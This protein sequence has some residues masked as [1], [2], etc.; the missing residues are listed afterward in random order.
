MSGDE[1]PTVAVTGALFVCFTCRQPIVTRNGQ[2][3]PPPGGI[4]VWTGADGGTRIALH[5]EGCTGPVEDPV[6]ANLHY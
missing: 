3:V 4:T 6:I 1:Q 5:A 2:V